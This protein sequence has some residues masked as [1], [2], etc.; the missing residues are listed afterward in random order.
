MLGPY[1]ST[2]SYLGQSYAGMLV[3]QWQP[4]FHVQSQMVV[5]QYQ[6]VQPVASIPT[7]P[8]ITSMVVAQS[9]QAGPSTPN[10]QFLGLQTVNK[11]FH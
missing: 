1:G 4:T 7:T 5:Y 6:P 2:S 9:A 10:P 11:V 8:T 3:F